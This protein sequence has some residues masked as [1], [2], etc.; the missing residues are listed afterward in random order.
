MIKIQFFLWLLILIFV[1]HFNF[2]STVPSKE[3]KINTYIKLKF[4]GGRT[5]I[6]VKNRIFQQCMYLLL[7][8]RVDQIEDYEEIDSIDEAAEKLD[9]TMERD[10]GI[11]SPEE[12][13]MGHCSNLQVWAENG[14]DT[15]ILHRNLAFPLLKRLTEVGDPLAKKVFKEEIAIRLGSKHPTVITFLTQNGYLKYL[16]REEL[17]VIFNEISPT[18]LSGITDEL[19]QQLEH[20]PPIN[21]GNHLRYLIQ[22]LSRKFGV[23]N[24]PILINHL[25]RGIPENHK[26][27]LIKQSYN[28]LKMNRKFPLIQFINEN[29][30]YFDDFEF[31][32]DFVKYH[33]KIIGIFRDKQLYLCRQ[34]IKN[35]DD[36]EILEEN[37]IRIEELD[38]SNNLISDIKGIEK[39]SNL[40]YLK[41]DN[42]QVTNVEGLKHLKDLHT[43][44]LRNNKISEIKGFENFTSLNYLDLS[45]NSKITE[46]PDSLN[47]IPALKTFKLWN[48]SIRKFSEASSKFFWMNQNYRF[49]SG[50]TQ[51]DKIY[52]E[53]TH[54]N[55]SSSTNG[56]FKQF[57]VWVIK[58]RKIMKEEKFTYSEIEKFEIETTQNALWWVRTTKSFKLW[59]NDRAQMRITEFI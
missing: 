37:I 13:F 48:C 51:T 18:I 20:Q 31:E 17:E 7:N 30:K 50:Y 47:N 36:I 21:F 6:Y 54:K 27:N 44:Y 49:Y 12:E 3:F 8:L 35:I 46:I 53:K 59:L 55:K 23:Q 10:H 34:K 43:L 9:R 19:I 25:L 45:G 58:I 41:L 26:E 1:L 52:Y 2:R 39:F 33:G 14:Y 38:L 29:I 11:I 28:F 22:D 32:F 40:K 5:N 57:V 42:N 4:E 16:N 56:L 15:R 24:L